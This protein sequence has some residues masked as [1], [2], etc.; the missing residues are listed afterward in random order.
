[1]SAIKYATTLTLM[2]ATAAGL[3]LWQQ[4]LADDVYQTVDKEGNIVY[5]D[6]PE[7]DAE[8][9]AVKL[10]EPNTVKATPVRPRGTPQAENTEINYTV[11]FA[12]PT[13]QQHIPNRLAGVTVT[14]RVKP[15]MVPGLKLR[16]LLN[17][18]EYGVGKDSF[19]ISQL[20]VG[21]ST[22]QLQ[23]LDKRGETLDQT[24]V[25]TIYASQPG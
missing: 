6:Q 15:K 24:P 21:P 8:A 7:P 25:I 5:T 2:I 11:A 16:L 3:L 18:E 9:E 1:M 17:G 14:A 20:P 13:D 23:L 19:V 4:A 22:L 12:S 10:Q